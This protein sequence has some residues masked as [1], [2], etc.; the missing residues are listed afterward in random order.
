MLDLKRIRNNS[1]EI[2]LALSN[3][4][5]DFD[6]SVID[7]VV[8]LDEERR[9]I[10]VEVEN[11]KSK[12]NQES[13]QIPKLK[14]A[15][16]S[17]DGIMEE[18]KK[19]SDEIK[20][21]DDKLGKVD[22]EIEYIMLRIPNIPNPAVP[23]GKSDEDNV[24]IR[25]WGNPTTFEFEPKAHWD[26][27]V[28]LNI[29]DFER[30]G[31]VTGSRFTFYK[32]VGARLERAVIN[33]F[34]NTHVD[35]NG[36]TEILPP[37]MVN[38]RSMTGTGQLPKFEEDAFKVSNCDYFLIPTAEVPVTNLYR[39]EILSGDTLPIKHVAYSAC[40]RSEAGS[41]GRDTR[42][43]VR[44]HQ[45]NK[46]ELVKFT[47]PEQSYEEL[48]KLTNDAEKVLQGLGLPYRVV[49]ICKGDLGF[50]AALKYDIEVWMPSYNRYVEISSCSNFEDFQARRANIKY[51][52][53]PKDKPQ[54]VH[55]LNGSGVA[56]GR[57]VAAILENFQQKD[58]SVIIPEALRPYFGG[59]EVIK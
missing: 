55:T 57:T 14:K 30:A 11:L 33:Y 20:K 8:A 32:G 21:L 34:L 49:R 40:F 10:L 58:G 41:A 50:T 36:Y 29:L 56:I 46:V 42:G 4:G 3:R 27:G 13:A 52:D 37:Y 54:F 23:D 16:E 2:K 22:E 17:V 59:K 47:K 25:R 12:R 48:E 18:M 38:R 28:D 5:E 7:K 15:G 31:K 1:E 9:N 45:F 35:E 26:L 43:L 53:N 44:Q 51:K 6:V 24:E 39:D 19:L